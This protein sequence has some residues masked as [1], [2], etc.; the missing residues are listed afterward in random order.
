MRLEHFRITMVDGGNFITYVKDITRESQLFGVLIL[1]RGSPT[2]NRAWSSLQ[3]KYGGVDPGWQYMGTL[4]GDD[5]KAEQQFR[6]RELPP[7]GEREYFNVITEYDP[8]DY[9]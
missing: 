5:K 3:R 1:R 7:K 6:H 9:Q 4:V 8:D 2:W